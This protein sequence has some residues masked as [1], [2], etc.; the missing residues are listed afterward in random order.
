MDAVS[1]P[2]AVTGLPGLDP[3][4]AAMLA[5]LADSG[6]PPLNELPVPIAREAYAAVS[7]LGG[8][9]LAVERILD[10][11]AD[12]VPVRVYWPQG[13][14]PHPVLIW[15]HGGGWT[16]G[17]V[18]V[19]DRTARAL[20]HLAGCMVVSVDYRLAPEHPFP[21]AVDDTLAASRWVMRTIASLGGDP[22]RLAIGGELAGGNLS[23]VIANELAGVFALQV[24]V[25]PATDLALEG[26]SI[27]A[28]GHRQLLTKE[29]ILWF[30]EQYADVGDYEN[31]RASP[32]YASPQTLA[33]APATL[34]IT[35]E[36]DPLRDDN[37]A[38]VRLLRDAGVA[39][40]QARYPG[41]IHAFFELSGMIPEALDARERVVRAL[42]IAWASPRPQD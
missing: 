15:V 14:G 2:H 42:Q 10:T 11:A 35:G 19:S 38:Y 7:A 40:E 20:C 37:D 17:S 8:E 41:Q 28:F 33:G 13:E 6:A 1:E 4:A 9:S 3:A 32:A 29:A 30:R 31:P 18:E 5:M 24:L 34:M 27:D 21:A 23:A 22:G 25:Y 12:G 26:A 16:V 39:V 36:L